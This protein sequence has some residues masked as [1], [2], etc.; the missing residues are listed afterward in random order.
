MKEFLVMRK[1][2]KWAL[3]I[4][5]VLVL[6]AIIPAGLKVREFGYLT[7]RVTCHLRLATFTLSA[8]Y[9]LILALLCR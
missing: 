9:L 2:G 3:R 6:I 7:T 4:F 5:G 1:I 8:Y